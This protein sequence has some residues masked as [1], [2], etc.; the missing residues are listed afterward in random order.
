ML[1]VT[2][3]VRKDRLA[4]C[5]GCKF[6]K[7]VGPALFCGTPLVGGKVDD[8]ENNVRHRKRK[9][10]LCGCHMQHK[11]WY[12]FA[13]CPAKKWYA[14]VAEGQTVELL[15]AK[16]NEIKEFILLL[17]DRSSISHDEAKKLHGYYQELSGTKVAFTLCPD[18]VRGWKTFLIEKVK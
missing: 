4:I 5:Q 6:H 13:S 1:L 10:K 18:C 14:V 2:P 15:E 8:P 11:T 16:V 7:M 9:V 17:G 3:R 12:S